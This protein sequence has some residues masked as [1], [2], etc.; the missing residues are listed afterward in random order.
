MYPAKIM[1]AQMCKVDPHT[2]RG[3]WVMAGI[4]ATYVLCSMVLAMFFER[5]VTIF[6]LFS[7][8]S[9]IIFYFLVP[10]VFML[11]YPRIKAAN[12][13]RDR[14]E[15]DQATVDPLI[16][17]V[18]SMIAPVMTRGSISRA[19]AFSNRVFPAKE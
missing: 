10:G 8:I 13:D 1:L 16:V 15:D 6:G 14:I 18:L 19:R 11:R 3:Y 5:I 9:G 12:I 2:R 7:A 4:T 17:G